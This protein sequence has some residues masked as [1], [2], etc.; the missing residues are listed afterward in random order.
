MNAGL[1]REGTHSPEGRGRRADI[2]DAA[3]RPGAAPAEPLAPHSPGG[4]TRAS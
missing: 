3:G 2:C 4:H 1:K